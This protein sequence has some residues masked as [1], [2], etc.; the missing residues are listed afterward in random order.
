MATYLV[1]NYGPSVQVDATRDAWAKR[2][3]STL[4]NSEFNDLEAAK[5]FADSVGSKVL[6]AKKKVLYDS[7]KP[8]ADE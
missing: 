7:S 6:D 4:Q 1:P 8:E 3:G 5:R 2:I